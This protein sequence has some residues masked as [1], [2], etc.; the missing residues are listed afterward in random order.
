MHK[1]WFA[2]QRE[3]G[4]GNMKLDEDDA[5]DIKLRL[6]SGESVRSIR[7]RYGIGRTTVYNIKNGATWAQV[8]IKKGEENVQE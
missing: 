5:M 3:A 4:R 6:K 1:N 7:D 2:K 8:K